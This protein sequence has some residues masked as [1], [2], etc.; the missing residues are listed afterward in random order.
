MRAL[1]ILSALVLLA[2]C[3][4]APKVTF[5][6]ASLTLPEDPMELPEGPGR[7]AVIEN[8]TACHSP[9]TML[10]QP[11]VSRE[12]WESIVGKM[13]KLYKAPVD[14]AAVPAIAGYMVHVQSQPEAPR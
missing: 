4:S 2:A 3:D 5:E 6:D 9:S 1:A 10:Q 7:D 11:K 14:D 13:K 12:K 8:C